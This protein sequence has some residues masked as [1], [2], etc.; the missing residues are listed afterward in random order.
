MIFFRCLCFDSCVDEA[1][2]S[3]AVQSSLALCGVAGL[4]T[5]HHLPDLNHLSSS[6]VL[7]HL[8]SLISRVDIKT[9]RLLRQAAK[10]LLKALSLTGR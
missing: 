10:R 6:G 8:G 4:S 7:T 5:K 3:V 9:P 2:I 1:L